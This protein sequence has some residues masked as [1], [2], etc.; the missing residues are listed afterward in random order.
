[1]Q[2]TRTAFAAAALFGVAERALHAQPKD[3]A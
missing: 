1:V 2:A 3:G